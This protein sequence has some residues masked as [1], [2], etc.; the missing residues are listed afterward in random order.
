[1][2]GDGS[3][4]RAGHGSALIRAFVAVLLEDQVRGALESVIDRLRPGEARVAWVPGSNLHLSLV[5]LG[6]VPRDMVGDLT[7]M[8]DHAV[9]GV[10]R[11]PLRVA[12]LG[13]FGDRVVWAEADCPDE[14]RRIQ[15]ATVAG[16]R[17]LEVMVDDRPYRPHITLGRVRSGAGGL[18]A[19]LRRMG[20]P[21]F[22]TMEVR[23]VALMRS[24][25]LPGHAVHEPL[26]FS[27]LS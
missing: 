6:N 20:R 16:A 22:G 11:F 14:L 13:M 24:S 7:R 2:G 5:F 27:L 15:E 17:R 25:L 12:G 21:E 19:A 26:H 10:G 8:L 23:R 3:Q 4:E 18:A 9:A 1:M